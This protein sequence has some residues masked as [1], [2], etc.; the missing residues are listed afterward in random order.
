MKVKATDLFRKFNLRPCELDH[1]PAKDE[2]FEVTPERYNL[3]VKGNQ[4]G[5]FVE[6]VVVVEKA[7]APK[8]TKKK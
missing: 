8:T 6:K 5:C 1:I 7:V 2:E 3:L 4:Y